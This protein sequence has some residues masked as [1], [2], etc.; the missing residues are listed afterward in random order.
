MENLIDGHLLNVLSYQNSNSSCLAGLCIHDLNKA[1]DAKQLFLD[2]FFYQY[3][4][5]KNERFPDW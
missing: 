5:Y 2:I 4:K 3:S 1:I